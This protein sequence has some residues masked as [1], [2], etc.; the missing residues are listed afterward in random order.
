VNRHERRRVNA[1]QE[2][3]GDGEVFIISP[4]NIDTVMAAAEAGDEGARA[5]LVCGDDFVQGEQHC[6]HCHKVE[7]TLDNPPFVLVVVRLHND[8]TRTA[9]FCNECVED[10]SFVPHLEKLG[11]KREEFMLGR[12]LQ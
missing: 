8:E 11:I 1:V 5:A 9:G 7:F 4:A 6:L 10:G 3:R 12:P 2:K